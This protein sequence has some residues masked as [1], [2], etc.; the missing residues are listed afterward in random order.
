MVKET[1]EEVIVKHEVPEA[2]KA[3]ADEAAQKRHKFISELAALT[4]YNIHGT[5]IKYESLPD[6]EQ[7]GWRDIAAAV[8]VGLDKL[9]KMVVLK[10]TPQESEGVRNKNIEVLTKIIQDFVMGLK[11][12]KCPKCGSEAELRPLI[13][14]CTELAH[15]VWNGGK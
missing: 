13:F 9:N 12:I 6:S 15:R 2:M 11:S 5:K 1:K 4:Y 14:P 3:V 10:V 7:K 8:L